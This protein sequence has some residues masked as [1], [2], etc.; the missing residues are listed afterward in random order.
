MITG[1]VIFVYP[2]GSGA[3]GGPKPTPEPDGPGPTDN[4]INSVGGILGENF[5]ESNAWNETCKMFRD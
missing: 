4:C 5:T 2:A 3:F 1:N